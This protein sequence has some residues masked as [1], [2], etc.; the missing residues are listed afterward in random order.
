MPPPLGVIEVDVV[1]APMDIEMSILGKSTTR[2]ADLLVGWAGA[3]GGGGWMWTP[4]PCLAGCRWKEEA[5]E[6]GGGGDELG[7]SIFRTSTP[8]APRWC[9]GNDDLWFEPLVGEM[10][11]VA[12]EVL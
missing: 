8:G 1:A 6:T 10:V 11:R 4:P 12:A 5:E 7:G 2:P 9:G 3:F